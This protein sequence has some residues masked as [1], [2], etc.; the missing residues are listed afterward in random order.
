MEQEGQ[1]EDGARRAVVQ[2]GNV[3]RTFIEVSFCSSC[4]YLAAHF[5]SSID[6]EVSH[7]FSIVVDILAVTQ[8]DERKQVVCHVVFLQD[9]RGQ[10]RALAL[11]GGGPKVALSL[12]HQRNAE[13][14][15][16][17]LTG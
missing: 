17:S 9:P 10:V 2:G 13:A 7:H 3:A 4:S 1:V 11:H 14:E 5:A 6:L 12:S 16:R 8:Q 15:A